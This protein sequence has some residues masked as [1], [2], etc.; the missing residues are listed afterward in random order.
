MRWLK[1]EFLKK[2]FKNLELG[3]I[4]PLFLFTVAVY[5]FSHIAHEILEEQEV[6]ADLSV[7]AYV[8]NHVTTPGLTS[9]M[10]LFT[11]AG[12]AQVLQ[13]GYIAL[14]I[15]YLVR[16]EFKRSIEIFT[17]GV[18]GTIINLVMKHSFH[19]LRPQ[20]PLIDPLQSFSFP[21]GHATGSF[22]FYGLLAYLVW[23]TGWQWKYKVIFGIVLISF[24][25]LIG[26]S[27]IYL[28]VHYPS[29]VAAG[30]LCGFAWLLLCIWIM[31]KT[32]KQAKKEVAREQ[33]V[34]PAPQDT[35]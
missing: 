11:Y 24:S 4:I 13:T 32:T 19:R 1:L 15:L 35:K 7:F 3:L 30:F 16:K 20:D 6:T 17:V 14:I 29:D 27:R 22:L 33:G 18:T 8:S 9:F 21:S 34:T 28:R 12:S 2:Y 23:K 26:F 31:E 25:M 10:K 5:F